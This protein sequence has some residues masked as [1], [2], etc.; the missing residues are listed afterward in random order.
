M[1]N[2]QTWL[3]E[4]PD[5]T[6]PIYD[7]SGKQKTD[8]QTGRP[9]FEL[10]Q[11]GTRITSNRLNTMEGG[12]EAAHTLVEQLAKELGGNFV[13]VIDGVMGLSCSAEGL[14]ATW[15]AG[16]A[17]V[18][19][20]RY[21]ISAGEIT[22]NPTQGQYLYVDIDGVIKKT[23]SE[24]TAKTG[25]LLFY[26]ATD[27]SGVISSTDGRVNISLEEILRKIENTDIP[28][29][30]LTV[31]GKV[32]LSSKTNG[33]SE[34]LAATEKAIGLV[35]TEAAAAKQLGVEQKALVVA[36]LNS[37]G[38]AASTS[39]RWAQLIPKI[40]GLIRATGNATA[41][42]VLSG[43]TFSNS[44]ANGLTGTMAN[45]GAGGTVTPGTA[46]Q[47][48]AAGYYSSAISILGDAD[49]VATNIRNGVDIFGVL[50]NL[51]P[52]RSATGNA[53]APNASI[54]VS[55]LAFKPSIVA[56]FGDSGVGWS[57]AGAAVD[58]AVLGNTT[59]N[60][61]GGQADSSNK[62]TP[63]SIIFNADGFVFQS[64]GAQFGSATIKWIAIE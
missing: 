17:Y 48:K 16:V 22:L 34:A 58:R 1:Y 62:Y 11:V 4:I 45:R 21:E 47:T 24:A 35:M 52:K 14:K 6:K 39:E 49:L 18:G 50:G 2:K 19:G 9:L 10:V 33:D 32:Q 63:P 30:S 28:D 61:F 12:I 59:G 15:T 27:T 60:H 3:D 54:V 31:K 57:I 56:Y 42:Q 5:M 43:A 40:S 13:A 25:L 37:I 51:I 46:N 64:I 53:A 20:R 41:A 23:T 8:P 38:V 55:G 36:A 26:V 7:A 44:S 29:A